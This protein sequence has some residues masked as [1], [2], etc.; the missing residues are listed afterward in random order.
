VKLKKIQK[1]K[2]SDGQMIPIFRDWDV[3]TNEGHLPKMVYATTLLPG[4]KKD[5]ILHQK[6][7]SY[8]TCIQG[9]VKIEYMQDQQINDVVL[10]AECDDDWID[11]VLFSPN[12]PIQIENTSEETAI[13]INCPSPSWHPDDQDTIKFKNWSEFRQWSQKD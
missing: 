4:I 9:S 3:E 12:I 1:I 6:R 8:M 11:L 2:T 13:I 10:D 5:I 7:S